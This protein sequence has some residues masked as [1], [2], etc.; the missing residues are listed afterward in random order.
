M[1]SLS[2][3]P[4]A[5]I[6]ILP[7]LQLVDSQDFNTLIGAD[8]S[9]PT[10][11]CCEQDCCGLGTYW[12]GNRCVLDYL[13]SGWNGTFTTPGCAYRACCESDC[14]GDD[15]VFNRFCIPRP[16]LDP[17]EIIVGGILDDPDGNMTTD[18]EDP[19]TVTV[20]L[21]NPDVPL[22]VTNVDYS[23]PDNL[24]QIF[25]SLDALTGN[26]TNRSAFPF[27][28]GEESNLL[29]PPRV[30]AAA[31]TEE[32]SNFRRRLVDEQ[33]FGEYWVPLW[34]VVPLDVTRVQVTW[35]IDI[36]LLDDN[37]IEEG[38]VCWKAVFPIFP[39]ST[40]ACN[41][42]SK[43]LFGPGITIGP[44]VESPFT[45]GLYRRFDFTVTGLTCNTRYLFLMRL[46]WWDGSDYRLENK[47]PVTSTCP[48]DPFIPNSCDGGACGLCA[49]PDDSNPFAF[50]Y[51]I[52][53]K[54]VENSGLDC[55]AHVGKFSLGSAVGL[56]RTCEA[57][58]D[59]HAH[60]FNGGGASFSYGG[61]SLTTTTLHKRDRSFLLHVG[62]FNGDGR[63]DLLRTGY[64]FAE[65]NRVYLSSGSSANDFEFE[66]HDFDIAI[67]GS[68]LEKPDRSCR[69]HVGDFNGD[70]R[71]D[72]LRSCDSRIYNALW[73]GRPD[74]Y[75]LGQGTV[76]TGNHLEKS[77][78]T[79]LLHL[80][81]FNG[82]EKT[83]LL[84]S[85]DSRQY[86][87]LWYGTD[88]GF[89]FHGRVLTGNHLAKSDGT[90]ALHLGNFNGDKYTDILRTCDQKRYNQLWLGGTSGFTAVTMPVPVGSVASVL[91]SSV[92]Q[93]SWNS[94]RL[95]VGDFNGDGASDLLRSCDCK[96][97]NR[98]WL[99]N[100]SSVNYFD[101]PQR[102]LTDALLENDCGT[103]KIHLGDF[104][105]D[106]KTDILRTCDN[107]SSNAVFRSLL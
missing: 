69:L 104:T 37:M 9:C 93:N 56:F 20:T 62:D 103:C 14:C 6:A 16:D 3:F 102:M 42:N 10:V 95:H 32:N 28:Q 84:R 27:V 31:P 5:A 98:L 96:C 58:S 63:M 92:L 82:D 15:Q 11:E 70:K 106:D 43:D 94:C 41:V 83:D 47:R 76:L 4:F 29:L 18:T 53:D 60:W 12:N 90:C 68:H 100:P 85:C 67:T 48:P 23:D 77:D 54:V 72:L 59:N 71:D 46:E 8:G 34:K 99:A 52:Q 105:G 51:V 1:K 87:A 65:Y 88:T 91:R 7:H 89:D 25:V 86:N 39:F 45:D 38:I 79:C 64:P 2:L 75:F 50:N 44:V 33:I 97:F 19:D 35:F 80:G 21:D 78:R 66:P 57:H 55:Q 26:I 40:R 22:N 61:K 49:L 74:G 30:N 17:D 101:F 73:Y 24:T 36:N 107:P 81:D 13:S